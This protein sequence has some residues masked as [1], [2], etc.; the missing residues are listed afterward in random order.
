MQGWAMDKVLVMVVEKDRALV[1]EAITALQQAGYEVI[2]A[3]NAA[4]GLK[5]INQLNP[6][7]ILA[8]TDL[9][10]VN[11]EDA[12]LRIRQASYLPMVIFGD[13]AELVKT[14]E[15]GADAYI[16]QP[17]SGREVVARVNS[18]LRR[19]KSG[20]PPEGGARLQIEDYL[21]GENDEPGG[22]SPTECR[23]TTCLLSNEGRMLDYPQLITE[24]WGRKTVSVDTLHFYIRR[25]RRKLANFNIFSMRGVGYGLSGNGRPE[26]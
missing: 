5:K 6:D 26:P 10:P 15:Q 20:D 24:V 13:Q 22:L 11:G 12:C 2:E 19:N 4:D 17:A 23:L 25:L 18:L 7:L 1:A 3:F 9:P 14:L 16:V 21:P 8:S